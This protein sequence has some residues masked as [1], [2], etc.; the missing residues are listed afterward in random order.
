MIEIYFDG[1]CEPVN[2]SGTASY[3]WVIKEDGR[4]LAQDGNIIGSGEGMTN[5]VSEYTGLI[6]ALEALPR[7]GMKGGAITIYGDSN[8]VCK[9]VAKKWGWKKK[10][11]RPH[12]DAPHLKV[13]L[14]RVLELLAGYDW[15]IEWIPRDRNHEA[16]ELSKRVLVE[17]GIIPPPSEQK[18]CPAC[19]GRLVERK[20][21]FSRFYGYSN[22][23]KCRFTE[24][25]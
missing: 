10:K 14:E 3:G 17:A 19:G 11:W 25:I 4:I 12:E 16:D 21:P 24:R 13:L 22:Y 15:Q 9:T 1:A 2:P 5:N 8:L 6:R 18:T 7:L 23:P 20:G